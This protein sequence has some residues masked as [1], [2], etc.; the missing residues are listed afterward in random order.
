MGAKEKGTGAERELVHLLW[1]QEWGASRVAGSG[2]IGYPVPDILASKNKRQLA[3]ECKVTKSESQYI[4]KEEIA[5]LRTFAKITGAEPYIAVRFARTDWR[6]LAPD[7]LD[8]TA[9]QFVVSK[10]LAMARGRALGDILG[11]PKGI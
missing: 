11:A 9:T 2:S 5:D 1:A 10:K 8:V 3:I 6:F 4:T 7:D